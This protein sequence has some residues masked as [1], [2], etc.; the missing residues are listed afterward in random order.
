MGH[1]RGRHCQVLPHWDLNPDLRISSKS[2]PRNRIKMYQKKTKS[3]STHHN[4]YLSVSSSLCIYIHSTTSYVVSN[5]SHT[6][7]QHI[8]NK[9]EGKKKKREQHTNEYYYYYYYYHYYYYYCLLLLVVYCS[10]F[11]PFPP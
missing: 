10:L 8:E 5:L 4:T 7:T 9:K 6:H 1:L 11:N 3:M 2:R